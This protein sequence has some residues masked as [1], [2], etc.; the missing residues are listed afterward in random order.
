MALHL[1][2]QLTAQLIK[3]LQLRYRALL[4]GCLEIQEDGS[5]LLRRTP[6]LRVVVQAMPPTARDSLS[7]RDLAALIAPDPLEDS[8]QIA[9][10]APAA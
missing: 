4:E 6:A 8:L 3:T 9:L 1:D 7:Q 2:A 5:A 10:E